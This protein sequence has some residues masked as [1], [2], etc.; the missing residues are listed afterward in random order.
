[1]GRLP[2]SAKALQGLHALDESDHE[3]FFGHAALVARL[4]GLLSPARV[5]VV[6][7]QLDPSEQGAAG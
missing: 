1:M 6:G 4:V 2:P 7:Q 3:R 5:G